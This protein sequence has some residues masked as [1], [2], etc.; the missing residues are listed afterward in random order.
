MWHAW[1]GMPRWPDPE[2]LGPQQ[3][4]QL[5]VGE[6]SGQSVPLPRPAGIRRGP[7]VSELIC[8]GHLPSRVSNDVLEVAYVAY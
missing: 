6:E 5:L 4:Q 1:P 7:W 2:Q 8:P 3:V